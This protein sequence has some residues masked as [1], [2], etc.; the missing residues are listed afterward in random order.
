APF[1]CCS[2]SSML[3]SGRRRESP[4][5]VAAARL[6][7]ARPPGHRVLRLPR[8][9]RAGAVPQVSRGGCGRQPA[10]RPPPE[11]RKFRGALRGSRRQPGLRRRRSP[12]VVSL[13][14]L[15]W[16]Y[17]LRLRRHPGPDALP[18]RGRRVCPWPAPAPRLPVVA[19]RD[20]CHVRDPS[21]HPLR[22]ALP[23]GAR[24][25]IGRPPPRSPP[26]VSHHGPALLHLD[27]LGLFP[28]SATAP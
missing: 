15:A 23:H 18:E 1:S 14:G 22:A 10:H 5:L 26:R 6:L 28:A 7:D 8:L 20:L 24:A 4:A 25:R 11:L 27:P 13:P 3:L 16:K 17:P 12:P 21:D 9:F 19:A 2:G